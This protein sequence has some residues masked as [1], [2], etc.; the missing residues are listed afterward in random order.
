[1]MLCQFLLYRKVIQS[2]THTHT[3]PFL[4][5]FH[6]NL[7]IFLT[8]PVLLTLPYVPQA[9][10]PVFCS[11]WSWIIM[12]RVESVA[13]KH[14][15]VSKFRNIFF[16]QFLSNQYYLAFP[17]SSISEVFCTASFQVFEYSAMKIRL[18]LSFC[19]YWLSI[20]LCT[21]LSCIPCICL[22]FSFQI[23]VYIVSFSVLTVLLGLF[24]KPLFKIPCCLKT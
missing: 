14:M 17:L 19:S 5:T 11:L 1:M 24:L 8:A 13:Q 7:P 9:G 12:G 21:L 20:Q 18:F 23:F 22:F 16:I 3:C 10:F 2:H 6:H 15:T 4:Y